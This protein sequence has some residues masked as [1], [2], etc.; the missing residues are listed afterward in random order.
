MI[1]TP[2]FPLKID[3]KTTFANAE[4]A[5]QV[6]M[7]H[8]KNLLLT[9][10]GEKI[11]DP[12]YGVGVKLYLFE[13]VT[14]ALLNNIAKDIDTAIKRYLTYLN[15]DDIRVSVMP[16]SYNLDISISFSI[17]ELDIFEDMKVEV[18]NTD[19]NIF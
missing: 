1:H 6:V 9:S 7:F 5:K 19:T 18:S 13:N 16:D 2:I 15:V 17:P 3:D 8:I 14:T 12:E 4:Q 10:P 11:S